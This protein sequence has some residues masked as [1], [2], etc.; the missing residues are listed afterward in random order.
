MVF[1][2]L[3]AITDL[4]RPNEQSA[5]IAD[6][7]S[8]FP[9]SMWVPQVLVFVLC[10]LLHMKRPQVGATVRRELCAE[11]DCKLRPCSSET[12]LKQHIIQRHSGS[13]RMNRGPGSFAVTAD[14]AMEPHRRTWGLIGKLSGKLDGTAIT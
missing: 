1:D 4:A 3:I 5:P 12:G 14:H 11:T 6:L 2:A 13:S 7:A 8:H 10:F 9:L